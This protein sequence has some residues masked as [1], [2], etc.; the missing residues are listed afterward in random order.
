MA[1]VCGV[2]FGACMVRVTNFGEPGA[3]D[4]GAVDAT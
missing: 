2:S 1:D 4:M 3:K